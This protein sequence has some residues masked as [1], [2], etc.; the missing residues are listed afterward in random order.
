MKEDN[1]LDLS[2]FD[3]I[4]DVDTFRKGLDELR[5]LD[6]SKA[7]RKEIEA[8]FFKYAFLKPI[9]I[10]MVPPD[11][12]NANTFYRVRT[13]IDT[14]REN[15]YLNGT[16][17]YPPSFVCGSNGRANLAHRPVFYCSDYAIAAILEIKPKVG[18]VLCVSSWK[19]KVD[20]EVQFAIFLPEDLKPSNKYRTDAEGLHKKLRGETPSFKKDKE[21]QLNMLNEFVCLQFVVEKPPYPITSWLSDEL[22]YAHMKNDLVLYPSVVTDS[23]FCNLAI[24]PNFVDR[25]LTLEKVAQ[26]II[27]ELSDVIS[28]SVGLMGI[29]DRMNIRWDKPTE[30]QIQVFRN[31]IDEGIQK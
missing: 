12:F 29:P 28:Y 22:L 5:K 24:H 11:E 31:T 19:P 26:I 3:K 13:K 7:S 30:E 2:P 6:L 16:F 10:M 4:P 9:Y 17:N 20:R 1:E 18:D 27:T 25:Y 14:K 15:V 23:R 8:T 21:E